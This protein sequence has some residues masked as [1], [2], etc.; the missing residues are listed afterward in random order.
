MKGV[1]GVFVERWEQHWARRRFGVHRI[2]YT[3]RRGRLEVTRG[4]SSGDDRHTSVHTKA[5]SSEK[6]CGWRVSFYV[7]RVVMKVM[8]WRRLL[9]G[10]VQRKRKEDLELR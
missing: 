2:L 5:H 8:D 4:Q 3:C 7:G 10:K 6:R 9:R 1:R